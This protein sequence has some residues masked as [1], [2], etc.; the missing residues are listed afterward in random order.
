[1]HWFFVVLAAAQLCTAVNASDLDTIR[2]EPN[3]EH[4]SE[5][6]LEYANKALDTARDAYQAGDLE[7]TQTALAD[8]GASV[9]LAF[10]SL[11]DTGKDARRSPKFFKRAEL[12]TREL[13]R[14]LES[15]SDSMSFQDRPIVEQLRTRVSEVHDDLLRGIMGRKKKK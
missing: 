14:R 8:V 9:D 5:Q 11:E 12:S 4:R 1:M 2:Q 6:A 15:L 13:L 7:K 10:E 3:L